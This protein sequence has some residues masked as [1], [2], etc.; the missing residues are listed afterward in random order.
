MNDEGFA[1]KNERQVIELRSETHVELYVRAIGHKS[2]MS[3][4]E[5]C[6]LYSPLFLV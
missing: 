3:I 6:K 1:A 4:E 2:F 5:E